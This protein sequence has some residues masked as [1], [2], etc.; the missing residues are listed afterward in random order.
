MSAESTGTAP[1]N[2]VERSRAIN[3]NIPNTG[4]IIL[5]CKLA[6]I[7]ANELRGTRQ[8]RLVRR[9]CGESVLGPKTLTKWYATTS[10][11][12]EQSR[13][14]DRCLKPLGHPSVSMASMP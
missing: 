3:V 14:Q 12:M 8:N 1:A 6:N 5:G 7:F 10:V 2:A 9:H 11:V 4:Q 13:F